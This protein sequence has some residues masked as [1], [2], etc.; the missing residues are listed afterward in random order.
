MCSLFQNASHFIGHTGKKPHK[1]R[2]E[3]CQENMEDRGA[4]T[5]DWLI[6]DKTVSE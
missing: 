2:Q 5:V 4:E 1:K 6:V 3:K